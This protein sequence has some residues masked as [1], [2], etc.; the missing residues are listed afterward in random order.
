MSNRP[1]HDFEVGNMQDSAQ[2][3]DDAEIG[4]VRCPESTCRVPAGKP[5]VTIDTYDGLTH[6]IINRASIHVE[7]RKLQN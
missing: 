6:R 7:R 3:W 4:R 5:C 1:E 2:L